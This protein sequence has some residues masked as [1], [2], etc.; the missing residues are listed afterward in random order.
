MKNVFQNISFL[1][2]F[3]LHDEFQVRK[4]FLY[5][6]KSYRIHENLFW[7]NLLI[8]IFVF[9]IAGVFLLVEKLN[10]QSNFLSLTES[11]ELVPVDSREFKHASI[12]I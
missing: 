1:Y 10:R 2:A 9:I 5:L 4:I 6:I 11:L 3:D 12:I 8:K 7:F